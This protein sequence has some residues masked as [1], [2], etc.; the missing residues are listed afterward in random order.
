LACRVD[1]H[2]VYDAL[3]G[4]TENGR[5]ADVLHDSAAQVRLDQAGDSSGHIG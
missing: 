1:E 4:T 3:A 2:Q 5:A